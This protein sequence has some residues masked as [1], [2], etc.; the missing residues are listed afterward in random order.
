MPRV[1]PGRRR[2]DRPHPAPPDRRPLDRRTGRRGAGQHR[3][4]AWSATRSASPTRWA[5]DTLV[6]VMTDGILLA[7]IHHD[8]RLTRYDTIILD[9]A[10]E[11]SLNIDFLLGYLRRLLPRRPRPQADRHLGHHRH[12]QVLRLLRRR[13]GGGGVRAHLPGGDS[14]TARS[15]TPT[16]K[17]PTGSAAG[18][19]RRGHRTGRRRHRRRPGV[20]LRRAGDPRRHRRH[21]RPAPRRTPRPSPL[22]AR[23]SSSEQHRVFRSHTRAVASWWPPT[24]P[25]PR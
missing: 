22:Y 23:L 1:G 7:E 17:R 5:T 2:A 12:R 13:P 8:R 21:R 20:L 10:H 18:D 14:A 11:R 3:R 15:T 24:S 16:Q 4:A 25:R 6:K 9:E 19:L